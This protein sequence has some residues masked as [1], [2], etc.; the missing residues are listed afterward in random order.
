MVTTLL[1]NAK[2]SFFDACRRLHSA[3]VTGLDERFFEH[4]D[5]KSLIKDINDSMDE[6]HFKSHVTALHAEVTNLVHEF[7]KED[8]K[9]EAAVFM[10]FNEALLKILPARNSDVFSDKNRRG[11][12]PEE[13]D[14]HKKGFRR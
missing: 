7:L 6:K 2:L 9:F 12:Y 11:V 4:A 5:I 10:N 1:D 14:D 3:E 13:S 8:K